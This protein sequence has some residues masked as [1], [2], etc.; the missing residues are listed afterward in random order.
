MKTLD[1]IT[2]LLQEQKPYLAERY[3]VTE[4]GVFGSYVKD[5]QDSDSD[6][7]IL[8]ELEEPPRIDL[9][10]LINLEFYLS[11]LLGAKVDVAL[12]G[13]LKK[14]IGRRI[15]SEVIAV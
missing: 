4:V 3:G 7:D 2:K 11:D 1:E 10:D 5:S 12:K 15:L 13:N 6:I 8:I 14:R 9:I